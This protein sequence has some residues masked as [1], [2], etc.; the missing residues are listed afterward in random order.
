MKIVSLQQ[1]GHPMM[2]KYQQIWIGEKK[3]SLEPKQKT[4]FLNFPKFMTFFFV[5]RIYDYKQPLLN[6]LE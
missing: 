1:N 3:Q 6:V 5:S 2:R 4:K